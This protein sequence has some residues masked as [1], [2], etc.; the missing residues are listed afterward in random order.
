[1]H[2]RRGRL[3]LGCDQRGEDMK[4]TEA[5]KKICVEY[6]KRDENGLVRCNECP[7]NLNHLLHGYPMC[8]AIIDGR[9]QEAKSLKRYKEE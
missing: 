5:E 2:Q 1:M 8:Y 7:L 3:L 6:A 9:T 4:L